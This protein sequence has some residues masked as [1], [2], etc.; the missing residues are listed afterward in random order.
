MS[1]PTTR[2]DG[3]GA[4][5][6]VSSRS[7]AGTQ[8]HHQR[9]AGASP[10]LW[11][12]MADPL[13]A[14]TPPRQMGGFVQSPAFG[15]HDRQ[16]SY[17]RRGGPCRRHR[18]VCHCR[19]VLHWIRS[20]QGRIRNFAE[21]ANSYPAYSRL[22]DLGSGCHVSGSDLTRTMR[23]RFTPGRGPATTAS[24]MVTTSQPSATLAGIEVLRAAD[25]MPSTLRS[26]RERGT[27][28][29]AI[30]HSDHGPS[31]PPRTTPPGVPARGDPADECGRDQLRQRAGRVVQRDLKREV[32]QSAGTWPDARTCRR[33]VF[34]WITRY[35]TRRRHSYCGHLA[36]A[37]YETIAAGMLTLAA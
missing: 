17:N 23:F 30:F 12:V 2:R 11:R 16:D 21:Q 22:A 7:P 8:L 32:Q 13:H 37:T 3:P 10:R 1:T 36:P 20:P 18:S 31:T 33:E 5:R 14:P 4:V 9:H 15:A 19:N 6:N 28:T 27:L 29:E 34:K 35:N 24:N 25:A 26:G